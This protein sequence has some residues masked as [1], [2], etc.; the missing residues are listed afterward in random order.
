MFL[1]FSAVV[2]LSSVLSGFPVD[3]S[4]GGKKSICR[5][6]FLLNP[7]YKTVSVS[8]TVYHYVGCLFSK[9]DQVQLSPSA[10]KYSAMVYAIASAHALFNVPVQSQ[11]VSQPV[12]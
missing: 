12:T 6:E 9:S 7:L 8:C 1:K 5:Q 3:G 11:P 10:V 4:P 2:L